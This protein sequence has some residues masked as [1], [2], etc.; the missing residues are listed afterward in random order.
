MRADLESRAV[1][2]E[3]ERRPRAD[4]NR[5][6]SAARGTRSSTGADL[7]VCLLRRGGM[8]GPD[9]ILRTGRSVRR[10]RSTL[11]VQRLRRERRAH[12]GRS[13]RRRSQ[14]L[15]LI[16][17]IFTSSAPADVW[18]RGA[19]LPHTPS[20]RFS[21]RA[22]G[23][24]AARLTRPRAN[25]RQ[26]RAAAKGP[27]RVRARGGYPPNNARPAQL[28]LSGVIAQTLS[29]SADCPRR[30]HRRPPSGWPSRAPLQVPRETPSKPA[31]GSSLRY[32]F[33]YQLT[34]IPHSNAAFVYAG[35][36]TR[37]S[38]ASGHRLLR[39]TRLPVPPRPQAIES[40]Y[41]I[42]R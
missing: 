36:R 25:L 10:L 3:G 23:V 8:R 5:Y 19:R 7:V 28:L 40:G 1:T 22:Y 32:Q 38:T 26:R 15:A 4:T 35:E 17:V 18:R 39:P 27:P 16:G 33:R 12:R 20:C 6:G 37:T 11:P 2:T 30:V 42:R 41:S 29:A 21:T 31:R 13:R 34:R 9:G 14:R 24:Q